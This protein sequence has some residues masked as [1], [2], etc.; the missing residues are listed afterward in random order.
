MAASI[1]AA[2]RLSELLAAR[3]LED[4]AGAERAELEELAARFPG[5]DLDAFER[6]AASLAVA[7]L[8]VEPMP[9]ELRA[10]VEA[11]ARAWRADCR[12]HRGG[13]QPET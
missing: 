5:A 2:D 12:A 7:G 13:A 6:V 1:S 4:L 3:A 9:E 10:R 11:D 8:R